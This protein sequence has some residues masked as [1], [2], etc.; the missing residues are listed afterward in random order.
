LSGSATRLFL[1][2]LGRSLAGARP[3]F[4]ETE[5]SDDDLDV[6]LRLTRT[7]GAATIVYGADGDLVLDG[8][9]ADVGAA[10]RPDL[11]AAG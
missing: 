4:E 5:T 9:R 1:D 3:S 7:T 2:L 8:L 11:E 6:R 10:A